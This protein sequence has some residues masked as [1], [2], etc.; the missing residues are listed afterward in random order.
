M[1]RDLI[2]DILQMSLEERIRLVEIIW[3]SIAG[4]PESLHLTDGQRHELDRRLAEFESDPDAGS[5]FGAVLA[6]I[7]G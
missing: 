1:K 2:Q 3:D 5:T 6:R 4:S 7:R